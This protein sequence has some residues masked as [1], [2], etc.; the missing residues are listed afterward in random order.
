MGL[1][2][3]DQSPSWPSEQR[4]RLL[5]P[6][7]AIT[8]AGIPCVMWAEDALSIVHRVPTALFDLQLLVPDNQVPAA[9]KALCA[10]LPYNVIPNGDTETTRW[11]DTKL[12]NPDLML[13][14]KEAPTRILVHRASTF[15]FG[16]NDTSR[17][18]LNP[19]P[20]DPAFALIRFP[21]I[22]AFL[23]SAVD[24]QYEPPLPVQ[25][26]KFNQHLQMCIGYLELYTL[27]DQGVQWVP[28]AETNEHILLPQFLQ[29][30]DTVKEENRPSLIRDFMGLG[31]RGFEVSVLERRALKAARFER[32]GLQY[33]PPAEIPYDPFARRRGLLPQDPNSGPWQTPYLMR[34]KRGELFI[35][36]RALARYTSVAIKMVR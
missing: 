22:T 27:S 13:P 19:A 11:R 20:P 35:Q 6:P 28:D 17:T 12:I 23:D 18:I 5:E 10:Q 14:T 33:Q 7:L 9:V 21:T 29:V 30:L 3:Y 4:G 36:W 2:F 8:K 26:Y 24:T 31:R 16:I 32:L 25:H 15:H 34:N 1:H